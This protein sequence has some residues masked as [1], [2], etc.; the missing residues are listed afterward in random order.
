MCLPFAIVNNDSRF[1]MHGYIAF[2]VLLFCARPI[3]FL[4]GSK[5]RISESFYRVEISFL[6]LIKACAR[7]NR[8][9]DQNPVDGNPLSDPH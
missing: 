9:R 7:V 4:S 3:E 2:V 1:L 6:C 5:A 8:Y